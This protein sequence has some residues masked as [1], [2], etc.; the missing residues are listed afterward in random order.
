M[1]FVTS[2]LDRQIEFVS[3]NA[4]KLLIP[5]V[6]CTAAGGP[7]GLAHDDFVSARVHSLWPRLAMVGN[8]SNFTTAGATGPAW[9]VGFGQSDLQN[10]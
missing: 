6:I 7:S 2:T 9:A 3:G 4:G 1:A 8:F 5:S 10:L